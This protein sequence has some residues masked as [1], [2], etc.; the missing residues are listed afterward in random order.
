MGKQGALAEEL[1]R[2]IAEVVKKL[3]TSRALTW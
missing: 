1:D 2:T 3:E